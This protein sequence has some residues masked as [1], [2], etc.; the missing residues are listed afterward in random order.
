MRFL[1]RTFCLL[2]ALLPF[3]LFATDTGAA[4]L[5]VKGTAWLNGTA[6]PDSSAIFPGDMIQTKPGSAASITYAGSN[7]VIGSDS[8]AQFEAGR[9]ELQHGQLTVVSQSTIVQ[10][11]DV[12]IA[13][14]KGSPAEFNVGEADGQVLIFAR[15]GSVTVSDA[16]GTVTLAEGQQTTRGARKRRKKGVAQ[17]DGRYGVLSSP[18]ARVAGIGAVGLLT[19][20]SLKPDDDSVSPW[21]P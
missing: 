20:L 9:V 1:C 2:L 12:S 16:S 10:V 7:V 21:H 15:K 14:V 8:L 19:T 4:M 18:W 17:A 5:Y 3:P 11:D 6:I 13:P